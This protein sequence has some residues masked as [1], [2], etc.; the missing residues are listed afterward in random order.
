MIIVDLNE[1]KEAGSCGEIARQLIKTGSDPYQLIRFKRGTTKVFN[2]DFTLAYWA[3]TRVK[4]STD[5]E[6]MKPVRYEGSFQ[7]RTP[8]QMASE[9]GVSV[10]SEDISH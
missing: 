9:I 2:E 4:E 5:G 3:G 7:L 1:H 6:W 10:L 8:R